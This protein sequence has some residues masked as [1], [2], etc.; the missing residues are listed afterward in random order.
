MLQEGFYTALGTPIDK[1]GSIVEES[2]RAE[3]EGQI[4]HGAAGMLLLGSMGMQPSIVKSECARA[5]RIASDA[6]AGRTALFV[7]VMDN[8]IRGVLERIEAMRG[9]EL[10]GVVLTTP[11]YFKAD[12]AQLIRYFNAV[13]D[14]S[15]FPV[16]LYDLPVSVKQKITYP[17]LV[18]LARH[19][20]IMGVKTADIV[21][22]MQIMLRGEVKNEFT[23]LYSG[24]DTFDVGYT[25]G[26]RHYLDGMFAAAPHNAEKMDERFR[27]G[28]FLGAK[29]YLD[30]IL[31]LRDT[32]AK[33]D[34]Q[35]FASFTW[36]MNQL[37]M[38]GFFEPD[39]SRPVSDEGRAVLSR[40][41]RD[42]GEL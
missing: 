28:D 23:P 38:D 27:A 12:T 40:M 5:A 21:M 37:G 15:P 26:I 1:D 42:V 7:G 41:L 30:N 9:L 3:I 36:V 33:F 20:N 14:V 25:H 10:T 6:T 34:G 18:E 17:M 31:L 32:M 8:S 16:Y 4:A 19:P 2:L 22:I 13:A 29:K 24:L 35:I 11:Y 39:Y